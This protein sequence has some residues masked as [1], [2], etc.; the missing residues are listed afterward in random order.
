MRRFIQERTMFK[1]LVEKTGLLFSITTRQRAYFFFISRQLFGIRI[2]ATTDPYPGIVEACDYNISM[3][4]N[5][6]DRLSNL[7]VRDNR[8]ESGS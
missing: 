4:I 5:Q 3:I 2:A 1:L 8:I 7:V 6:W